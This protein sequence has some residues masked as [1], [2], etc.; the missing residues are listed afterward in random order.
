VRILSPFLWTGLI[1]AYVSLSRN[2]PEERDLLQ[3]Q[4]K[5]EMI[6][7]ALS[8]KILMGFHHTHMSF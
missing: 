6:K 3:I 1:I 7:E 5:G 4:V 8:F 2:M